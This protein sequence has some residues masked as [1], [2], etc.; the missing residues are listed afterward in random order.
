MREN[1]SRWMMPV[2]ILLVMLWVVIPQQADAQGALYFLS[3]RKGIQTASGDGAF[4]QWEQNHGELQ[5]GRQVN[6]NGVEMDVFSISESGFGLGLGVEVHQY[7]KT[8]NFED[9]SG[10]LPPEQVYIAG[11]GVIF[12]LKTYFR[13]GEFLPYLGAGLGNYYIKFREQQSNLNSSQSIDE[14]YAFKAGARYTIG[15]FG[16]LIETGS[17]SALTNITLKDGKTTIQAG[18]T[19]NLFGLS[20]LF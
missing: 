8:F 11:H 7:E 15:K 20:Y 3:L 16:M 12:S 13:L 2:L 10:V 14:V 19:Y 18:G 9:S 1:K 6:T 5:N 4:D 17:I